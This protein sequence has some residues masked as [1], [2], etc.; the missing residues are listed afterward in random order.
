MDIP[1]GFPAKVI[2]GRSLHFRWSHPNYPA[3]DGYALAFRIRRRSGT[4]GVDIASAKA[5]ADGDSWIVH[6]IASETTGFSAVLG[7]AVWIAKLTL[8]TDT[9]DGGYGLTEILENPDSATTALDLRSHAKIVLDA[10]EACIEGSATREEGS[11]TVDFGGVS[12]ALQFRPL[13]E[14]LAM[15]R[16]YQDLVDAE[17][18]EAAVAAGKPSGNRVLVR[19]TSPT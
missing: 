18:A 2:A 7:D 5:T 10:I 17:N 6:L 4:G 12:R 9:Y 19:F 8:S 15:K 1:T 3:S 11:L 13:T 16:H 14:L